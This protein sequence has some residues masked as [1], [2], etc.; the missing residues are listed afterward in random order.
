MS[1]DG[2]D[3]REELIL[4]VKELRTRLLFYSRFL[5]RAAAREPDELEREKIKLYA[6]GYQEVLKHLEDIFYG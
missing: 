4:G 5:E 6:L 3:D 1:A 2:W